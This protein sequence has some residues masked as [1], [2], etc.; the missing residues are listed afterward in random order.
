MKSKSKES[1]IGSIIGLILTL[2]F[3]LV[4]GRG[5]GI[6]YQDALDELEANHG[7]EEP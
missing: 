3:S 2:L 7:D 6:D 5:K 1:G 4:L